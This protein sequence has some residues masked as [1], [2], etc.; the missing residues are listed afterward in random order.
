MG[1]IA[2][3]GCRRV[4]PRLRAGLRPQ[5]R[6]LHRLRLRIARSR[7]QR[8]HAPVVGGGRYDD[9]LTRARRDVARSRRRL[10]RLVRAACTSNCRRAAMSAPSK[11]R[12][13]HRRP[14]QGPAAGER[15]SFFARAG[16]KLVRPRR[17]RLSRRAAGIAG[18]EVAYLSASEIVA[19]LAQ[20]AAHL[21]VTGEDLVREMM[22]RRGSTRRAADGAGLR[23][24]QRRGGGAAGLDRRAHDGRSRGRRDRVPRAAWPQ[25]AGRDEIRQPDARASSR[26]TASPITGSSKASAPPKARPPPAPAELIVDITTTGETLAANALKV[27]DDGVML[28]SQ[29]NLVA[30]INADWGEKQKA[31]RPRH[32]VAHRG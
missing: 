25:D 9:L 24:R 13:D 28:R 19:Q 2:A 15:A 1:F 32:P 7:A 6:L 8:W 22:R 16:L 5:S 30:S 26:S 3:R 4:E 12:P 21:G 27:I 18:V 29:A 10:R 31:S 20:G 23:P 14:F 17:A 11:E